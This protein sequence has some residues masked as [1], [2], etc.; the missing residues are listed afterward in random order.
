MQNVTNMSINYYRENGTIIKSG[1]LQFTVTGSNSSLFYTPVGSSGLTFMQ[2]NT[3]SRV[4]IAPDSVSQGMNIFGIGNQIWELTSEKSTLTVEYN[5]V[6]L[7]PTQVIIKNT[8]ITGYKD[9]Q[10]TL[11]L[12]TATPPGTYFTELAVNNYPSD[13]QSQTFSSQIINQTSTRAIEISSV[14]PTATG[15][16]VFRFDNATK[17]TYFVGNFSTY[18]IT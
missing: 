4:T 1:Y 18:A 5:N 16:F 8:W 7:A 10:S 15:L 3:G 11:T 12:S 6:N 14:T 9:F 17:S 13:A 2:L